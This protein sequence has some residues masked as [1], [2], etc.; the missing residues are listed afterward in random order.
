VSPLAVEMLVWFCTRSWQAGPFPNLTTHEP[1]KEIRNW[2]L[3]EGVIEPF[4]P[5][6]S[7]PVYQATERG[8]AWLRMITETPIPVQKWVDPREAPK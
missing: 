3:A 1:Q 7:E 6:G 8:Q 5:T 4:E 2:M